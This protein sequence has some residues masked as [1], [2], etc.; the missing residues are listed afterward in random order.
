MRDDRRFIAKD[1]LLF[2]LYLSMAGCA[3]DIH[4]TLSVTEGNGKQSADADVS[5]AH[6]PSEDAAQ[7]ASVSTG[8]GSGETDAKSR[9]VTNVLDP[10]ASCAGESQSVELAPLDMVIALD[11]SYSMDF[12]GKWPAVKQ[13]IN[14]FTADKSFAGLGMG[15]QYFPI[16][17]QCTASEY[18][19]LAVAVGRIPDNAQA[20]GESLASQRMS[21]GTPMAPMLQGVL[22]VARGQARDHPE[23]NVVIVLA[24]DGIPDNTCTKSIE[25][26]LSNTIANVVA[27]AKDGAS[28]SPAIRTFV[29]G[30]GTELT[31]LNQIARA[32]SG[33]DAFFVDTAKDIQGALVRAL[34]EIRRRALSCEHAVPT[35]AGPGQVILYD[36]VNVI[37]RANGQSEVFYNVSDKDKC[38]VAGQNAWYYDN[39]AAP[40]KIVLCPKTCDKV[41]AVAE[42]AFDVQ[43]GC[44]TVIF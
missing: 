42:G 24:T 19:K 6:V 28:G 35:L 44:K 34:T 41:Q 13:A 32:G 20:I 26:S 40:K 31:A 37:F 16:R 15:I 3:S 12:L 27:V 23:R 7:D 2:A 39:P 38:A 9:V 11:T 1:T 30:V 14:V 29:V 22:E 43:F 33:D 8:N 36:R 21:G 10:D 5:D 18:A 17:G 25:G 4:H